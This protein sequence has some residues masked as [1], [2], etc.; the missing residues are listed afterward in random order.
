MRQNSMVVFKLMQPF[1]L[2][3]RVATQEEMD[4]VYEQMLVEMLKVR[5]Y[6]LT[7]KYAG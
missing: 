5:W 3:T 4:Q 6:A 2:K 1:L 7:G